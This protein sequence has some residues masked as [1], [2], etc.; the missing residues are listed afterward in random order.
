M[1]EI[2]QKLLV[3]AEKGLP[4]TPQPFDQIAINL[5]ISTQE[6]ILRLRILQK[7][8]VIRRFGASVMPN[9]VGYLA[10]AMVAWKVPQNRIAEVSEY[11]C[12]RKEVSHCY[13]REV[14]PNKWEYNF[15]TV[16]HAQERSTVQEL[17]KSFATEAAL[18]NYEI[19]F[20][21]RNLKLKETTK[22]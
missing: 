21:T 12:K 5:G 3:E 14:V 13:E 6:V 9:G 19:L 2:D 22:C 1:D 4:L 11:F 16:I 17:V 8:G 7:N 10:N 18:S 15:Y 20:S